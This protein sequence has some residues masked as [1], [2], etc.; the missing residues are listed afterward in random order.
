MIERGAAAFT[1]SLLLLCVESWQW[2]WSFREL[3]SRSSGHE[4]GEF[5]AWRSA[6]QTLLE[7]K[8]DKL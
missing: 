1:A 5:W 8:K 4:A 7:V 2:Q 6:P 3:R